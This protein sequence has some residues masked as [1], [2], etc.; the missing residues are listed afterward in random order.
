MLRYSVLRQP[1]LVLIKDRKIKIYSK[2]CPYS[3][4]A[5]IRKAAA[6]HIKPM[7]KNRIRQ[8]ALHRNRVI[9]S[10]YSS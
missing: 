2:A 9:A 1:G 7:E 8:T 6:K 4:V 10:F 5:S 3:T